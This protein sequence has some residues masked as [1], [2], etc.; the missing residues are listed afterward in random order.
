VVSTVCDSEN[1]YFL[2]GC[3]PLVEHPGMHNVTH[4][5]IEDSVYCLAG[6]KSHLFAEINGL[7]VTCGLG[8]DKGCSQPMYLG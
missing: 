8:M 7:G 3:L 2:K 5:G 4:V 6:F 1:Q